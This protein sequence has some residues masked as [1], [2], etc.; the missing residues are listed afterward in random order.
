MFYSD[1]NTQNKQWT[2]ESIF[3]LFFDEDFVGYICSMTN[4]YAVETNIATNWSPVS[5][6]KLQCF[7]G[8][9][10]LSGYCKLPSYKMYWEESIDVQQSIVK[11]AISCNRYREIL[12]YIHFCDNSNINLSDKCAKVRPLWYRNA[13]KGMQTFQKEW[14][15]T[16]Q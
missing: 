5:T 7:I 12:W 1:I 11:N 8:I 14:I 16:N 4:N 15:L 10:M 9:L 6:E 13:A 2:P 3:N